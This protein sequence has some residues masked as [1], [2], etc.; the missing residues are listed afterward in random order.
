MSYT[1]IFNQ[2]F[3]KPLFFHEK[4]VYIVLKKHA[5][6]N[7]RIFPSQKTIAFNTS[8]SISAVSRALSSL[9]S[10]GYIEIISGKKKGTSNIYHLNPFQP[11]NVSSNAKA[12]TI[13]NN[14]STAKSNP[15]N[16]KSKQRTSSK[17]RYNQTKKDNIIPLNSTFSNEPITIP[18]PN[19]QNFTVENGAIIKIAHNE[20]AAVF[21]SNAKLPRIDNLKMLRKVDYMLTC[22][23][24]GLIKPRLPLLYLRK[25]T[26]PDKG[27][28]SIITLRHKQ[29]EA[30]QKQLE[31]ERQLREEKT[32]QEKIYKLACEKWNILSNNE[33]NIWESKA[34]E[35][36][37]NLSI[38]ISGLNSLAFRLFGANIEQNFVN[39]N[40]K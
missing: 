39:S 5:G 15:P 16:F 21:G 8:L 20:W 7:N 11:P 28:E 1:T 36:F 32:K 2:I 22:T 18:P 35:S 34:K 38:E 17:V 14:N 40:S 31:K 23:L 6:V 24:K 3:E 9:K 26:P 4:L 25:V 13:P 12:M 33:R 27:W 30:K 29:E 19:K 37:S 10:K